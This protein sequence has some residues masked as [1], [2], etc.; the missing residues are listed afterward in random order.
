MRKTPSYNDKRSRT[1]YDSLFYFIKNWNILWW[2]HPMEINP[3]KTTNINNV[4]IILKMSDS[5]SGMKGITIRKRMG[6]T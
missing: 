2:P 5:R 6:K 1:T 4:N 3:V